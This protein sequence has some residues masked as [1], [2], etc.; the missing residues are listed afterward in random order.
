MHEEVCFLALFRSLSS[1]NVLMSRFVVPR[2]CHLSE[3]RLKLQGSFRKR[4]LLETFLEK[5]CWVPYIF[6]IHVQ[7]LMSCLT[8]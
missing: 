3:L 6:R 5:L 7:N 2:Q 1:P 8:L 4:N